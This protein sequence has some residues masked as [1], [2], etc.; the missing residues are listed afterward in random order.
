MK[1]MNRSLP[2]RPSFRRCCACY[3]VLLRCYPRAHRE[4]FGPLMVQHFRDQCRDA[5]E[6]GGGVLAVL[7]FATRL[8]ADFFSSVLQENLSSKSIMIR[9]LTSH[10][11]T[12]GILLLLAVALGL[13]SADV[14]AHGH[15][16]TGAILAYLS[17]CTLLLRGV[18]ELYRPAD[19]WLRA[20]GWG[21]LVF[22]LYGF[23]MP[24]WARFQLI[25][26][27]ES[28]LLVVLLFV[29]LG[30]N[31]VVPL[32]KAIIALRMRTI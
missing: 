5:A 12:P 8:L 22:V 17:L 9:H 6:T 25:P 13:V 1:T 24:L 19:Q 27:A 11:R 15:R 2:G 32:G 31:L 10:A 16:A 20:T 4:Q 23:I 14:A 26:V 18:A 7:P 29:A 21:V 30:S 3:R 28:G